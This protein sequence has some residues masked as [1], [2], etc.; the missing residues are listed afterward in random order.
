MGETLQLTS[1]ATLDEIGRWLT[2]LGSYSS[3]F[4]DFQKPIGVAISN[5]W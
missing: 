2:D 4:L 3:R 5:V 1:K